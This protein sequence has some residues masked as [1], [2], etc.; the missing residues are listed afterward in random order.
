MYPHEIAPQV[1]L[2]H[3]IQYLDESIAHFREC[4]DRMGA[5][6]EPVTIHQAITRS[7]ELRKSLEALTL[8]QRDA[9]RAHFLPKSP[10]PSLA[11]SSAS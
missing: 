6:L 3:A 9:M 11:S 7:E 8:N 2:L 10:C 4:L 1:N 5:I